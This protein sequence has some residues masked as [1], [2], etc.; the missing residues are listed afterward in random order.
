MIWGIVCLVVPIPVHGGRSDWSLAE[1]QLH[2]CKSNVK[3]LATGLEMYSADNHGLYPES[4]ASLTPTYLK[5]IPQCPSAQGDSYSATYRHHNASPAAENTYT[6]NCQGEHHLEAGYPI[7]Y[8]VYSS[9]QGL[10]VP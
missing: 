3:N 5:I 2:D 1:R 6:V 4:L 9:T 10:I 7:D 8:P